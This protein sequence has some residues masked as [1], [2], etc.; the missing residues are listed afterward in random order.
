VAALID[1]NVLSD[2]IHADPRWE[3]WAEARILE[4]FGELFINPIIYAEL[5][6]RADSV[7]ELENTLAPFD[8]HYLELPKKALFLAAQA[9]LDY[10]N[11]GG[12]RTSPLPDF[13][14]GAHAVALELPLLT[15]DAARY[16]TYFPQVKLIT[17]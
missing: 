4:H 15:R 17:P 6:C 12:S 10:R 9:F 11:R 13:F 16:R 8:L 2:V 7:E 3:A 14:I 1:T 5:A